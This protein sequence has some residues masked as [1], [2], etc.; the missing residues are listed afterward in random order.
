MACG[1]PVVASHVG[2]I[3]EVVPEYAGILVPPHAVEALSVAL[4]QAT[5]KS[6]D[7]VQIT[8]HAGNFRWEDNISRLEHI[9][10]AVI[11]PGP[12][13]VGEPA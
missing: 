12:V 10:Q 8:A 5:G 3:P 6:W 2:G 13:P 9:L 4:I 1:T 7:S 11:A